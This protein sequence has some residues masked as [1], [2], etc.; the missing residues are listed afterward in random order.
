MFLAFPGKRRNG[1]EKGTKRQTEKAEGRDDS[2][3]GRKE[4]R[5]HPDRW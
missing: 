3:P 1:H 2:S 4:V 5:E